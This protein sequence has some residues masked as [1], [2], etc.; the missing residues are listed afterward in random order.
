MLVNIL[1]RDFEQASYLPVACGRAVQTNQQASYMDVMGLVLRG[2]VVYRDEDTVY[3][4]DP[5]NSD[6]FYKFAYTH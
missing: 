4:Q 2:A 5:S 3:V 1:S 6:L